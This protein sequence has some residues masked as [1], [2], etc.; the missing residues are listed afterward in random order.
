MYYTGAKFSD[1]GHIRKFAR[2]AEAGA[3]A[4]RL[5]EQFPIL[6]RY[7][8]YVAPVVDGKIAQAAKRLKA[9]SGHEA[10]E[11]ITVDD[12]D[13]KTGLVV[14]P[15]LAIG[16]ETVRDGETLPYMHE[17]KKTSRPL[18]A[19]SSDGKQL[20]I[21]GGRFQFTERGIVDRP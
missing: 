2:Q 19:A 4:E 3:V 13:F 9:F 8:V 10:S 20:R 18:L 6:H 12:K 14:G 21:V 1:S 7:S 16:Y 15:V 5:L 17:F 11:V